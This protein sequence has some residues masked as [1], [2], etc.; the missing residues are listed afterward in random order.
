MCS[1]VEAI[2]RL[3][4]GDALREN[5]SVHP[6]ILAEI[7]SE[8]SQQVRIIGSKQEPALYT[9]KSLEREKLI[10]MSKNAFSRV[11]LDSST[12]SKVRVKH[13]VT[14]SLDEAEAQKKGELLNV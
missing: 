11:Q 12:S 4:E 5:C 9:V 3:N 14:A 7:S 8:L 13:W 2:V 1:C 6:K 10:G